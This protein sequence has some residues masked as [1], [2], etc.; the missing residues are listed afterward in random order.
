M[1]CNLEIFDHRP[2]FKKAAGAQKVDGENV[3]PLCERKG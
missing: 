3:K 2:G 1:V